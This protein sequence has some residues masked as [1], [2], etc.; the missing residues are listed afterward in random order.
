V[1]RGE[2]RDLRGLEHDR[3]AH[4]ERTHRVRRVVQDGKVPGADHTDDAERRPPQPRLFRDEEE[5]VP[6]FFGKS[7]ARGPAA[8]ADELAQVEDLEGLRLVARLAALGDERAGEGECVVE[9]RVAP[10]LEGLDPFCDR[11]GSPCGCGRAGRLDGGGDAG[12]A[13]VRD[14][15]D[16]LPGRRR[17]DANGRS[18]HEAIVS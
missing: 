1:E 3:V 18:R 10:G 4:E 12:R 11:P 16:E 2:R 7:A 6:G 14:F 8:E 17:H 9:D 13:F 15:G 5:R